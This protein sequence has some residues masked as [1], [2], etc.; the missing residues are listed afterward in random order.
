MRTAPWL[1]L[2]YCFLPLAILSLPHGESCTCGAVR[3]GERDGRW[4]AGYMA[5][6]IYRGVMRAAH[7]AIVIGGAYV[8]GADIHF[9]SML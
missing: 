9:L 2:L 8:L 6:Q 5:G 4:A 1:T 7:T 3:F